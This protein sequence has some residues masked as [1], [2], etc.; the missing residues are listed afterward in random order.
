MNCILLKINLCLFFLLVPVGNEI[1]DS[2]SGSSLRQS[3]MPDDAEIWLDAIYSNQCQSPMP[4][5]VEI[6][7]DAIYSYQKNEVNH[8]CLLMLRF[9]W[10]LII[11]VIKCCQSTISDN[12]KLSQILQS[13]MPD[14]T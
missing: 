6:W 8:A 10:M 11:L 13:S 3:P 7:L 2:P 12:S 4:D 9:D 1:P 14:D 5:D